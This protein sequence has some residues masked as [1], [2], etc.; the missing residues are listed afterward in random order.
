M[1]IG[2][3]MVDIDRLARLVTQSPSFVRRTFS[4]REL[5]A[6]SRMQN[7][8]RKE[9]L[10]GRFAVK[11]AALKALGVGLQDDLLLNEI[12]TI[13]LA[14]GAPSLVLVG[15]ALKLARREGIRDLH[16]SIS[17]ELRFA[18]AFVVLS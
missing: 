14:S 3:D 15:R 9:Y 16:V 7:R 6:A 4:M 2:V 18:V 1:R 11:E 17:H 10:A 5:A 8:Q 12:E 13:S